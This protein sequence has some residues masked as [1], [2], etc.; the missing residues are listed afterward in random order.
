MHLEDFEKL[1]EEALS[2]LP[3]QFRKRLDNLAI[4]V[5]ENPSS[6]VMK[7]LGAHPFSTVLGL[8]HGVPLQHKGPYYGNMPPDVIVIYKTPIESQ[9]TTE[10]QIREKVYEVVLHE[11]GH[12]FGLTDEELKKIER[13]ERT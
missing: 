2:R 7:R 13:P 4:L 5:E 1:V 9:C 11:V 3:R 8:Y 10:D 12:Y 6:E